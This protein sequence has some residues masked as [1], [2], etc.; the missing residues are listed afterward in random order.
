MHHLIILQTTIHQYIISIDHNHLLTSEVDCK[1]SFYAEVEVLC[2]HH[3]VDLSVYGVEVHDH[4]GPDIRHLEV[5]WEDDFC[6]L[7]REDDF[8]NDAPAEDDLPDNLREGEDET[9]EEDCV[10]MEEDDREEV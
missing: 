7:K 5:L 3:W 6:G 9:W 8:W 10:G 1:V 4:F 2:S